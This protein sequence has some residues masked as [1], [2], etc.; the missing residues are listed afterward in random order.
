VQEWSAEVTVDA[1]LVRRLVG[2]QFP[3][4][5]LESLQLLGEGWDNAVWL[6]DE[7]WVFRFPRREIAVPGVARQ[8]A[9]LPRLAPLLALPIPEPVF[10]GRP[11]DGFPWPF[12]GAPYLPG[13]EIADA[14]LDDAAR[15]G[16]ARPLGEFLRALHAADVEGADA[17]PIDPMG[18]AD[19]ALRVPRTR[20]R[21][22]EVETLGLWRSPPA[23]EQVLAAA[24]K[25]PP[26]KD[27]APA[28]GDLHFRHLLV[29]G[30]ALSGVVDWDDVCRGDPSIDLQLFWSLLP[31]EGRDELLA[32]YGPLGEDQLLRA[33]V[34]ALF[35]CA[36]LAAYAEHEGLD[37]I[38]REAVAG[39]DRAASG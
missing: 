4:L 14:G 12:Y 35:L 13:R 6:V 27:L 10:A 11:A 8:I 3:E 24:E 25:L 1:E 19:M 21:L 15:I 34:L 22:S 2:E 5:R 17:L 33:R 28:H 39:L 20:E 31:P 32:A 29:D 36:A 23:V 7:R 37:A 16:L 18:R 9:L 30:G 26:P 38:R